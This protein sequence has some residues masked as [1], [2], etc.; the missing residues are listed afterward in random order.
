MHS[1]VFY[2]SASYWCLKSSARTNMDDVRGYVGGRLSVTLI[3][4]FGAI[5]EVIIIIII[6]YYYYYFLL[7]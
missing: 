6:F 1:V 7:L 4:S 3:C 2:T 5:K